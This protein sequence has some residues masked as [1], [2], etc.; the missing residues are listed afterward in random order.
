MNRKLKYPEVV[1]AYKAKQR[2][3]WVIGDALIRECG[4]PYGT[5]YGSNSLQEAVDEIIREC[6]N[7]EDNFSFNFFRNIRSTAFHFPKSKRNP[8]IS[9]DAHQRARTPENLEKIIKAA[10]KGQPITSSYVG[11]IVS[12]WRKK[13]S[14]VIASNKQ[15]TVIAIARANLFKNCVVKSKKLMRKAKAQILPALSKLDETYVNELIAD[16]LSLVRDC[17]SLI[18]AM[19]GK[20]LSKRQSVARRPRRMQ[21]QR[22]PGRKVSRRRVA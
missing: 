13:K 14:H 4:P 6:D 21:G 18:D 3:N 15:G 16:G 2:S 12:K 8:R 9:F 20:S 22:Q 5:L 7:G 17:K 19:R 11:S 10:P 1:A